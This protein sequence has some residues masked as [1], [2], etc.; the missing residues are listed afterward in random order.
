MR[1]CVVGTGYV[2]LVTGA[3]LAKVGHQVQCVDVRPEVV[4]AINAGRS[5]IVEP[6]LDDILKA[7]VA[8]GHFRASLSLQEGM[9]GAEIV[10]V[11]VGTPTTK[12][13][14]DLRYVREAAEGIGRTLAG[15]SAYRVVTVK[16]TVV[17]GTT[18]GL[19]R[20][21]LETTSGR[22]AG[23]FGLCMNP[24][25][26]REGCAVEDFLEPDRIV[27]GQWDERSGDTLAKMYSPFSCPVVRTGLRNAELIKYTA[28][29]LL[30]SMISFSNQIAMICESLDGVDVDEVFT[31]V[32]L[33]RLLSPVVDGRRVHPGLLAYLKAG[34][35]Y[36][37]SCFPKDVLALRQFAQECGVPAPLLEAVMAVNRSRASHL[38]DLVEEPLG[39]AEGKK[40]AVLGLTFK[41]FTDDLRESPAL[42]AV[43]ELLRRGAVVRAY[44][45][46]VP[47]G[48]TDP[49]LPSGLE[50]FPNAID[51]V[52]EAQA[53][54]LATAWPEF[55]GL[56]WGA[57]C[58]AMPRPVIV[59]GRNAL[60]EV[61]WPHGAL[62]RPI[63]R[64][65]EV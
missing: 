45:P 25:F 5:P 16:S 29:A 4:E 58:A 21:S 60:K 31:G 62:Y 23:Q 38:A 22:K 49:H 17:P 63:G 27:I 59:D 2:G 61:Q 18:D 1:V 9:E 50:L 34:A 47:P 55:L 35:G 6:G 51:A 26:L 53:V 30:A 19:V 43:E 10:L 52:R 20:T 32:H 41:P 11:A 8:E 37:G 57:V 13:D 24:E 46:E 40:V 54:V 64:R 65:T 56:D 12:G 3:C 33:D 14:I 28:N 15:S 42:A 7:G 48:R 44:D 39:G 36:G